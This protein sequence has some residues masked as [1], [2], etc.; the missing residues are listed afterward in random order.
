MR[1]PPRREGLDCP[2]EAAGTLGGSLRRP[3]CYI[4]AYRQPEV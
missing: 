1:R 2:S 3:V 4:Y